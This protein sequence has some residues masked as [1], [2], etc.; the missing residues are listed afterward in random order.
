MKFSVDTYNEEISGK[1]NVKDLETAMQLLYLK[2][3]AVLTLDPDPSDIALFEEQLKAESD[4]IAETSG[5]DQ[6]PEAAS[7]LEQ[8]GIDTERALEV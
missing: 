3:G 2:N 6:H 1:S 4:Y 8:M 5:I 7:F